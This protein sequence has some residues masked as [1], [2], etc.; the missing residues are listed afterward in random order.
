MDL[1][2]AACC[3]LHGQQHRDAVRLSAHASL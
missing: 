2:L 3:L 1:A